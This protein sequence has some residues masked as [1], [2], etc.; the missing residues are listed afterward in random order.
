[1]LSLYPSLL[2]LQV[3][4]ASIE[5]DKIIILAL[6]NIQDAKPE[7]KEEQ[8]LPSLLTVGLPNLLRW[9]QTSRSSLRVSSDTEDGSQ[10]ISHLRL[11]HPRSF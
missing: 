2:T 6:K 5:H 8:P 7:V 4:Q 9:E 11:R 10:Q 1:M 3:Q